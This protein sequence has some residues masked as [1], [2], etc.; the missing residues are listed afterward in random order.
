[1]KELYTTIEGAGVANYT[2]TAESHTLQIKGYG[3][4]MLLDLILFQLI[5]EISGAGDAWVNATQDL[6][7]VING[8][9]DITYVR[10]PQIRTLK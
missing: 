7:G 2:G 1:M 6:K 5:L 3:D 4:L 10:N 8:S 9:G